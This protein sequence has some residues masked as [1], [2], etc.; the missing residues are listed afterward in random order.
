M[1]L[2]V[3][4]NCLPFPVTLIKICNSPPNIPRGL[5]IGLF[6]VSWDAGRANALG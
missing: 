2:D 6:F 5:D 4:G 3:L 1:K